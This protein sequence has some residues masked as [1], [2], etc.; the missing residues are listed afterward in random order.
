MKAL[1]R[2][3]PQ[4]QTVS[5]CAAILRG[6]AVLALL[7]P[8][9]AALVVMSGCSS[10]DRNAIPVTVSLQRETPSVAKA[11]VL[12]DYSRA[13]AQIAQEGGHPS[14]AFI[15]PGLAG[16]FADDGRGTLTIHLQ[17]QPGLRGPADIAAC[18]MVASK[19]DTERK[20]IAARLD[21]KLSE[22]ED[23]GGKVID[24]AAA[25]TAAVAAP[26][27]TA[28]I[29]AK[30]PTQKSLAE[31]NRIRIA[32]RAAAAAAAGTAAPRGAA[33]GAAI[34]GVAGARAPAAVAP[35]APPPSPAP[36]ATAPPAARGAVL[37]PT[38]PS[39][40]R[41]AGANY[42]A[43]PTPGAGTS[44]DPGYDDTPADQ[45]KTAAYDV[46]V[47]VSAAEELGA[48][49]FMVSHTGSSGGWIGRGDTVECET[50]VDALKASNYVGGR[51]VRVGLIS[52]QGIPRVTP[53]VTCGFRSPEYVSVGSFAV[54]VVD[55]SN[56]DSTTLDPLPA[57]Q[58]TKVV[59]R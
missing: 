44:P 38:A 50:L 29:P 36:R 6:S 19:P 33:K 1:L 28:D 4:P 46:T 58:V 49:Q 2:R 47:S 5:R 40:Q 45:P 35:A 9:V 11:T 52:T 20:E 18:R 55:A 21:V 54:Q 37:T 24:L 15:M 48:L 26:A 23:S 30:K 59:R 8:A 13:G 57:V 42:D 32:E 43:T 17:A 25:Q 39:S 14:C 51:T 56:P 12:V 7:S 41:G 53:V 22:A 34:P 10:G 3:L 31:A 16:E 27:A